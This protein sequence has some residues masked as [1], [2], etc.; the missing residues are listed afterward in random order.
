[1]PRKAAGPEPSLVAGA[2]VL[3][4]RIMIFD[5]SAS[6]FLPGVVTAFD[7]RTGTLPT[8]WFL[9]VQIRTGP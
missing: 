6:D 9:L 8:T 5:K 3:S 1:M 7:G 4:R 2:E